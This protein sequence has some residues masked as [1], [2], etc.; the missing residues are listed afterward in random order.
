MKK[1][2][3]LKITIIVFIPLIILLLFLMYVY[4]RGLYFSMEA[5][6]KSTLDNWEVS[7]TYD[8]L[9]DKL[10][11]IISEEEFNDRTDIG[12]YDLYRKLE[13]LEVEK[14]KKNDPSTDWYKTPPV[15]CVEVNGRIYWI[16]YKIDF[17]SDFTGVKVINFTTDIQ[18]IKAEQSQ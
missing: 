6:E 10:K 7:I 3:K 18:E 2:S 14:R 5:D 1:C 17:R 9:S 11:N 15:D 12:K 8:M 4:I 13:G 16:E